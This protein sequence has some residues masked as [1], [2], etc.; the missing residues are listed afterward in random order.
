MPR[1]DFSSTPDTQSFSPLPDGKYNCV[2]EK[3]TERITQKGD[4]QY[5]MEFR[6]V[7]GL[8]KDRKIFDSILLQLENP[9]G[10]A[11]R[12]TKLVLSRLG[13][14]V[15]QAFQIEPDDIVNRKVIVICEGTEDYESKGQRR[16]KNLVPFGGYEK[17]PDQSGDNL[18]F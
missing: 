4:T 12:R 15:E 16:T 7:D 14:N 8:Y 6:V 10:G 1:V 3:C 9:D 17:H 2:V 5:N 18:P 11:M 13:F